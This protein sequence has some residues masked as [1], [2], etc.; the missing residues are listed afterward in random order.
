MAGDSFNSAGADAST[1]IMSFMAALE[2]KRRQDKLD[3]MTA[4]QQQ[5]DQQMHLR[6]MTLKEKKEQRE[7]EQHQ[8]DLA[9]RA[10]QHRDAAAKLAEDIQAKKQDEFT[11]SIS[12][13][14]PGDYP[15][16]QQIQTAQALGMGNRFPQPG[17]SQQSLPGVVAPNAPAIA[18][19]PMAA[20]IRVAPAPVS[21][22][23]FGPNASGVG[24]PPSPEP[25]A[26]MGLTGTADPGVRPFPG[27]YEQRHRLADE[28]ALDTYAK[29]LP[30]GSAARQVV[31][32]KQHG[33]TLTAGDLK[34]DK[35]ADN[36][37]AVFRQDPA[38]GAVDRL[39]DGHWL[40]WTG[41]VPKG[42]HFMTKAAPEKGAYQMQPEVDP[43][44]GKPTGRIFSFDSH[45]NRL[46]FAQLPEGAE[47][48]KGF[49]AEPGAAQAVTRE[50]AKA[51]ART[52]LG[53]LVDDINAADK[54]GVIG[55]GAGRVADFE[56]M[57]GSSNPVASRLA[58]RMISAKMQVDAGIG[59]MRAAASPSL[60][61]RWDNILS[62]KM[63]K[64]NLTQA[65]SVLQDMVAAK[66]SSPASKSGTKLTPEELHKKYGGQ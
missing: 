58:A 44:T 50:N 9:E 51:E 26:Q 36:S 8:A 23:G 56:R 57:V 3:A 52:T 66:D 49:K 31:E 43:A 24:L 62:S 37:E 14:G 4:Q 63:T 64:E 22:S 6:D 21:A 11:K 40:P 10:G 55:P 2:A 48:P 46:G 17:V 30:V 27:T 16:S 61:A 29:S 60:L 18:A 53:H 19:S 34:V 42:A 39:V 28:Q 12:N 25:P 54:A 47:G 1:G 32:A 5:F 7:A 13:M 33:V 38:S 41:D 59:G 20:G 45:N 35:P 65:V 15:D